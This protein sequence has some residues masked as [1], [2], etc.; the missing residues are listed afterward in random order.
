[1]TLAYAFNQDISQV[2]WKI[3][4]KLEYLQFGYYF[5]QDMRHVAFPEG[6]STLIFDCRKIYDLNG[7]S[8]PKN[9]LILQYTGLIDCDL[10]H[11][12]FP[13]SLQ[14]LYLCLQRYINIDWQRYKSLHT[15]VLYSIPDDKISGW[16]LFSVKSLVGDIIGNIINLLT[17]SSPNYIFPQTLKTLHLPSYINFHK[18]DELDELHLYDNINIDDIIWPQ[19]LKALYFG[20]NFNQSLEF[21]RWPPLLDK[22][23]MGYH[24]NQ[25]LYQWPKS[26]TYLKLGN[27]FEQKINNVPENLKTLIIS[28]N[29]NNDIYNIL[30]S[31]SL[32]SIELSGSFNRSINAAI[33]PDSLFIIKLGYMFNQSISRTKFPNNLNTFI[34]GDNAMLDC[35][36]QS[37]NLVK[38]PNA[39]TVLSLGE[40]FNQPLGENSERSE[41]LG[42]SE[43]FNNLCNIIDIT[44][45]ESFNQNIMHV[46][47]NKLYIVRDCSLKITVD[48]CKFPISLYKIIWY[49]RGTNSFSYNYN[50]IVKYQR[51]LGRYTKAASTF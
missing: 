28:G 2:D 15:L 10:T 39:L 20:G 5:Y 6:L 17:N 29:F 9:L 8:Y 26:L 4:A 48:S 16:N 47:F 50:E 24:Y 46:V 41:R 45:G 18:L 34:I 27:T 32:Y 19:S 35:Y 30:W 25:P 49:P 40:K 22:L 36:N 12:K 11:V 42:G 43:C 13:V 37:I 14:I 23:T 33:W 3:I 7:I 1:M 31:Q 51:K 44:F 38:F 21:M